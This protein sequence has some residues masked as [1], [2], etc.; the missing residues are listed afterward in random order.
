MEIKKGDTVE[1]IDDSLSGKVLKLNEKEVTFET[2][3]GFEMTFPR[4][5]VVV[6]KNAISVAN[7]EV[8]EILSEKE[9]KPRKKQII[10]PKKQRN[11][12][13]LEIDLHIEK[14]VKSPRG[15]SNY[16]ML[17]L[18]L[19]VAERQLKFALSKRIQKVV[20]IHGV[21]E[22]VLKTE[23]EFLFSRYENVRYYEADY[24]KYGLGAMEIYITQN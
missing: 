17:N 10:K 8:A 13:K 1:V 22:G 4:N 12:P 23:L 14:L 6:I 16:D 7:Y 19:E 11:D 2:E 24:N 20:F 3:D 18:Q 5:E 9:L 15:M 21:G